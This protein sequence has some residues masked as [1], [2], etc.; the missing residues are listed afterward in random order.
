[1]TYQ[2]LLEFLSNTITNLGIQEENRIFK[3]TL[4]R[5]SYRTLMSDLNSFTGEYT[6]FKLEKLSTKLGIVYIE[7]LE[8]KLESYIKLELK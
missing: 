3:L 5:I 6:K 8:N 1:M 7:C 4:D 2:F